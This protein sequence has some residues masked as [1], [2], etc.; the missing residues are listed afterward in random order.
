MVWFDVTGI[1]T[2]N[3]DLMYGL[4]P[5]LKT[6][7]GELYWSR[8]YPSVVYPRLSFLHLVLVY[9]YHRR[10]LD[11][12]SDIV[13]IMG[14]ESFAEVTGNDIMRRVQAHTVVTLSEQFSEVEPGTLLDGTA[15][16]RIQDIWDAAGKRHVSTKRWIY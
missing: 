11:A 5:E 9:H 8:C 4:D 6:S 3:K 15:S 2:L 12:A 10:T 13:G 16:R 7:R 14:K 1:A